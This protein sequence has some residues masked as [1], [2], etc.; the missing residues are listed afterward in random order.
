MTTQSL[1]Y[2]APADYPGGWFVIAVIAAALF[3]W[4]PF[5]VLAAIGAVVLGVLKIWKV[6]RHGR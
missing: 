5:M 2:F 4:L 1:D 3:T 6:A